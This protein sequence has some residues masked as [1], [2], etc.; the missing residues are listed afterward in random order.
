M[1]SES[2]SGKGGAWVAG[3]VV[4]MLG[5]ILGGVLT[6]DQWTCPV[7][8]WLAGGLTIAGAVFGISGVVALGGNRTIFPE[9]RTEGTLVRSGIYAYV[10]HPLY[11][12]VMC[13]GFAWGFWM[14][15]WVAMVGAICTTVFLAFKALAEE[16]RLRKRFADYSAYQL[17]TKK[18]LPYVW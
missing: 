9:P 1:T 12:S 5:T 16:Q 3:Q 8:L 14:Q 18:F 4:L 11:T 15:S 10:R 17:V 13:L 2:A 6:R 7:D